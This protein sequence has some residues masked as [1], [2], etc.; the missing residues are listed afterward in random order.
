MPGDARDA[1]GGSG[2][3]RRA[4]SDRFVGT[5]D[6]MIIRRPT[7]WGTVYD[8]RTFRRVRAATAR[9]A[10]EYAERGEIELGDGRTGVIR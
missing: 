5:A 8:A 6:E 4:A 2:E 10:E 3:V 7:R 9:D 1:S